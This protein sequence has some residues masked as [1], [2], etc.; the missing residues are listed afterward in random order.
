MFSIDLEVFKYRVIRCSGVFLSFFN[1]S[2]SFFFVEST[3]PLSFHSSLL[4][5]RYFLYVSILSLPCTVDVRFGQIL[6]GA[7]Q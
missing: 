2:S 5:S 6:R 1:L 4:S 7:R 3:L